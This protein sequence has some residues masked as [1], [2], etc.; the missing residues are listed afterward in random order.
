LITSKKKWQS[1]PERKNCPNWAKSNIFGK[2]FVDFEEIEQYLVYA[3]LTES[4]GGMVSKASLI[5]FADGFADDPLVMWKDLPEM[6]PDPSPKEI[7]FS[8]R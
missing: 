7:L 5:K 4:Q 1:R 6:S 3:L 8:L 2:S